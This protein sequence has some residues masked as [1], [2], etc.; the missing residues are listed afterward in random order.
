[1]I[2]RVTGQKVAE[3]RLPDADTVL[4]ARIRRLSQKLQ[5]LVATAEAS[6]GEL[7]AKLA[8]DL[9]CSPQAL[10]AALLAKLTEGQGLTLDAVRREQPEVPSGSRERSSSGERS[11][12]RRERA[13]RADGEGARGRSMPP[14]AE[15]RARCRAGVGARDGIQAKNLLGA[16]LNEGGLS[17]EALGRIQI[18]DTFSLVELPEEGLERLLAKLKDTRVAGKQLK[19]RRYRED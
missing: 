2:E 13:P 15:G 10:A 12:E 11:G 1:V 5:P 18:R 6:H 16:I 19:L 17:R 4:Q 9:E 3:V 8:T 7:L 14:V